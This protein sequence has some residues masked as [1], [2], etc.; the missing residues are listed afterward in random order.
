M[1]AIYS[2]EVTELVSKFNLKTLEAFFKSYF[3]NTYEQQ[4]NIECSTIL[5]N[6]EYYIQRYIDYFI[7]N[8][9]TGVGT[10][11]VVPSGI[12]FYDDMSWETKYVCM[13]RLEEKTLIKILKLKAFL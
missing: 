3:V 2:Q 5:T 8:N 7:A 1:A 11:F 10:I 9:K 4:Y 13:I 6:K 12:I